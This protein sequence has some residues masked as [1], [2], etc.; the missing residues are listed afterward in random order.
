MKEIK[1][2]LDFIGKKYVGEGEDKQSAIANIPYKGFARA[3][4]LLTVGEKTIAM[5]AMQTQRL[6]ALNPKIRACN[7]KSISLRF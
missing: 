5:S 6:F 1:A 7:V 4:S 2:T 3:K